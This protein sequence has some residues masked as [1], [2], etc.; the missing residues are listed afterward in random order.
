MAKKKNKKR[1]KHPA[2]KSDKEKEDAV[3]KNE[4][5]VVNS[6]LS[7]EINTGYTASDGIST[8]LSKDTGD[9]KVASDCQDD[10]HDIDAGDF[11]G[12]IDM[13]CPVASEDVANNDQTRSEIYKDVEGS[14][15]G[16]EVVGIEHLERDPKKDIVEKESQEKAEPSHN[17]RSDQQVSVSLRVTKEEALAMFTPLLNADIGDTI[18][19]QNSLNAKSADHQTSY[20][21]TVALITTIEKNVSDNS[22]SKSDDPWSSFDSGDRKRPQSAVVVEEQET[23]RTFLFTNIWNWLMDRSCWKR[24]S[25]KEYRASGIPAL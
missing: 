9:S 20:E 6:S 12:D 19:D 21:D 16:K 13:S 14:E 11:L 17:D 2:N 15:D 4:G 5:S 24:K 8:A 23:K 10:N 22:P 7:E 1:S 25:S 18:S 3:T